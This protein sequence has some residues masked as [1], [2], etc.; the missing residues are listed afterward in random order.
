[1]QPEQWKDLFAIEKN[2]GYETHLKKPSCLSAE[3][4]TA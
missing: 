3:K 1:M 2:S 4:P